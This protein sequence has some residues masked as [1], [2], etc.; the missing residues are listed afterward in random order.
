MSAENSVP[1]Q[2][3][4]WARLGGV[5]IRVVFVIV[6][7]IAL[8]AGLYFGI[9]ALYRQFIQPVQEHSLR[10]NA[11]E[12][13]FE[14]STQQQSRRMEEL[15]SRLDTLETQGDRHKQSLAN[16]Q[17]RLDTL[18]TAQSTQTASLATTDE[19]LSNLESSLT[20]L[21]DR[22]ESM[23]GALDALERDMQAAQA[24]LK[25]AGSLTD[26]ISEQVDEN[27][28]NLHSLATL[29]VQESARWDGMRRELQVM[30][31]MEL[32]TR[33][34]FSLAQN[35]LSLAQS[36]IRAGR[37]LLLGLEDELPANQ[38]ELVAEAGARLE[39]ALG[40]LPRAPVS[41]ADELEGA[42]QLLLQGL[43]TPST[44]TPTRAITPTSTAI[45]STPTPTPQP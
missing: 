33:S 25:A 43:P 37:E 39:S 21:S 26:S 5:L 2:P 31:V 7:G 28:Q 42:W 16:L 30:R 15:A 4:F 11:L 40:D 27:G 38:A 35:N 22:S 6:I 8:G 32:I 36:D 10:L 14:Q 44:P 23:Q 1:P 3:S 45:P 9:S 29:V 41:A 24:D 12:N 20:D 18:E 34:R 17:T 19:N 13:S